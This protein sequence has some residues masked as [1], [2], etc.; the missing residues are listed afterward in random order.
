MFEANIYGRVNFLYAKD[1]IFGEKNRDEI[2]WAVLFGIELIET[3][4]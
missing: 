2:E 4:E 1:Y 3:I